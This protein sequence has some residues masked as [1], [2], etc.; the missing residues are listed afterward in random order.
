MS[1]RTSPALPGS[2]C[3]GSSGRPP[4]RSL[5]AINTLRQARR[6]KRR[7]VWIGTETLVFQS[8][9]VEEMVKGK[10]FPVPTTLRRAHDVPEAVQREKTRGTGRRTCRAR[11]ARGRPCRGTQRPWQL[12][13]A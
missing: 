13:A 4:R 8:A 6:G 1:G 10:T 5:L 11:A 7:A 9:D 2:E 12:H 3:L